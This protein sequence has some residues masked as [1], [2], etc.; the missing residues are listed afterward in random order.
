MKVLFLTRYD[1]LGASSRVRI[2]QFIPFLEDMGWTCN[3]RPLFSDRYVRA[4]YTSRARGKHV[5]SGYYRRLEALFTVGRYDLVWIEKELFPFLP[6]VAERLLASLSWPYIVDYD[7]ALFHRYDRHESMLVRVLL[8]CKIDA[9]MRHAAIVVAGNRYLAARAEAAGAGHV[10]IVPTVV[11]RDR[12][13][14]GN[15]RKGPVTVGWVGSPATAHYLH[16]VA[17]PLA[18]VQRQYG[19]KIV[20]IGSGPIEIKGVKTEI[21][22]WEES[23]EVSMIAALDIGLM[24]LPNNDWERGKCGYKLIQYMACGRP[25]VASPVGVNVEIVREGENGYLA[26]TKTDWENAIGRLVENADLRDEMGAAGRASVE[27][28][29]SLQAQAPNLADIFI[30]AVNR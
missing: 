27:Q 17:E 18:K 7:D 29:Y 15:R 23:R 30:R 13:I 3:A 1:R 20:L 11:D 19:I 4:I 6:A 25:V 26:E 12:Y 10:E 2:L 14:P 28:T 5:V 16:M 8:G 22:A 21:L 24:P 9:V